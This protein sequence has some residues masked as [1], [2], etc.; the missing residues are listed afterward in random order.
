MAL[1]FTSDTHFGHESIRTLADRPFASL[2]EMDNELVRRWNAIV[3]PGDTVWHL[4]DFAHRNSSSIADYRSRLNGS[5]NL[6]L[7]NHDASIKGDNL[8]LFASVQLMAEVTSR[9][10]SIILCHYPL[11]EW[12]KA[13]RGAWHLH[14]HVHGR[15]DE[16]INGYSL[17]VGVDSHDYQPVSFE[18][19]VELFAGRAS[20]FV[21]DEARAAESKRRNAQR[22][23]R[24]ST[25]GQAGDET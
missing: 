13:W 17:D 15:L 19:I 23:Q 8:A 21:K 24:A 18:R 2:P 4:G 14:G 5:I 7:G 25:A 10:K 9:G 6:V 20:P 3:K 12:D 16:E 22:L 11:R 1:Y